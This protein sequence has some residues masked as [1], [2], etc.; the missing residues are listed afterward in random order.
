MDTSLSHKFIA[1]NDIRWL[2]L[3]VLHFLFLLV[4]TSLLEIQGNFFG[5]HGGV[6]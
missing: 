2:V 4:F 5:R 3:I 6:Y 1:V